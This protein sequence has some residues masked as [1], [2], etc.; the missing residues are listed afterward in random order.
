MVNSMGMTFVVDNIEGMCDLMCDNN[1]SSKN[2]HEVKQNEVENMSDFISREWILHTIENS[3]IIDTEH[4]KNYMIHLVRDIAP[5]ADMK[6]FINREDAISKVMMVDVGETLIYR[7]E[8][9]ETLEAMEGGERP[10]GEWLDSGVDYS[11]LTKC[12]V[13]GFDTG[14]SLAN[15]C[16]NCGADMRESIR[17]KG[18][19]NE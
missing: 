1:I 19:N 10:K 17:D 3:S 7:R 16:P 13:C 14:W 9:I 11:V 8:V 5:D 12:S 15:F 6:G 18:K 4:D 2:V